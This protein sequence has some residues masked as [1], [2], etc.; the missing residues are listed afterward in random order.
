MFVAW[1]LLALWVLLAACAERADVPQ[2]LGNVLMPTDGTSPVPLLD[3]Q[4]AVCTCNEVPGKLVVCDGGS[5]CERFPSGFN[6]TASVLQVQNTVITT[7]RKGDLAN[8]T[9]LQELEIDHNNRLSVIELGTFEMMA[10]LINLSLSYNENLT[11][12]EAGVFDGLHN[13]KELRMKKG[14]FFDMGLIS[15]AL[16]AMSL[17]SLKKLVLDENAFQRIDSEDLVAMNGSSLQHLHLIACQLD[18]IHPSALDPLRHLRELLLGQN[19]LNSSTITELVSHLVEESVPL[20]LLSLYGMGFLR[21]PPMNVMEAVSQSN[22]THLVLA[23]NQFQKLKP[24]SFPLMPRLQ[25]LDLREIVATD[26]KPGTFSPR[27]MPELKTLLFGGNML[28]GVVPGV[29]VPQLESLDL[30]ANYGDPRT[31]S[32]F[33]VGEGSFVNMTNLSFLNLSYNNIRRVSRN[34]FTGLENLDRHLGLKNASIYHL[35]EGSFENLGKLQFLNLEYNPFP[36]LYNLTASMFRGLHNLRVLLLS[37]CSITFLSPNVFSYL[38]SLEYL[39]LR[40]N[41]LSVLSPI[42]FTPLPRLIGIDLSHNQLTY[43]KNTSY[44]LFE[45]NSQ[46]EVVFLSRNKFTSLNPVMLEDAAVLTRLELYDNDLLC[47]CASFLSTKKWLKEQNLSLVD[48]HIAGL[49]TLRCFSPDES[50]NKPVIEYVDS[51]GD[52]CVLPTAEDQFVTWITVFL[53]TFLVLGFV[54]VAVAY[55]YRS[56]IRYWIFLARMDIQRRG[57]RRKDCEGHND[58]QYDAFLSYSNEDRNFVVRLVAMLENY[59][60]FLKLCV[61]ERDFEIGS[62]ISE[63]VLQSVAMS[64]RTLL[65]ISDAFAR[66]QW[67]RWELQIAENHRLFLRDD[68]EG[69]GDPLIMIKLGQVTEAHMTPTLRYLLRTRIYLEW[70]SEPRKQR[71][72]WDKLRT[73]LAPPPVSITTTTNT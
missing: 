8:L 56:Y 65:V 22:I 12:L 48:T 25:Y 17:P 33:D 66:S 6:T 57:I 45:N 26:L 61:Y 34:T 15:P 71:Q 60:P 19:T 44:R 63:S 30:S 24:G 1:W 28:S 13:L 20:N 53:V 21:R 5:G 62:V 10:S 36:K 52:A 37:G 68:N 40:D 38:P 35:Q 50:M 73:A 67:C 51:L 32:Y 29:L 64:R 18:F 31:R 72:F 54:V 41:D 9:H 43:P 42:L 59:E 27:I 16:T 11:H 14:G 39:S 69:G 49:S 58:H 3:S 23:R 47:Q 7:I 70:D 4:D 2:W 55:H 46:L